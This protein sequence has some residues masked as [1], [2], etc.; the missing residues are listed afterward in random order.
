M[1]DKRQSTEKINK[2]E[3]FSWKDVSVAIDKI[4]FV[5]FIILLTVA[6]VVFVAIIAS[7]RKKDNL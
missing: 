2:V 3:Q 1:F 5:F 4:F 6:T 7:E